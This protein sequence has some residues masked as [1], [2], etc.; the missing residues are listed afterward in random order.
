MITIPQLTAQALGS[1]SVMG[2]RGLV[3]LRAFRLDKAFA[4]S[5]ETDAGVHR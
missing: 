4:L 5:R 1:F 3:P 2:N